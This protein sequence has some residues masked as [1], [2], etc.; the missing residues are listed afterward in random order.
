MTPVQTSEVEKSLAQ[1]NAGPLCCM[2][3]VHIEKVLEALRYFT[4]QV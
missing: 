3:L 4:L 2:W 1:V